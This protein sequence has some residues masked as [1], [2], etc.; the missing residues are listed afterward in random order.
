MVMGMADPWDF[1]RTPDLPRRVGVTLTALAV[2]RIGSWVPLPGVDISA[3]LT[4]ET[5]HSTAIPRL[6]IMALGVAP[7]LSALILV[8]VAMI[9]V[10]S[11]RAWSTA[12][13]ERKAQ[14]DG[15]AFVLALAIAA[16]QANGIAVALEQIHGL[17]SSPG[18]A[19]RAGVVTSLV[20]GS[21]FLLWIAALIT[22][23]G[24][25]SGFWILVAVP[26]VVSFSEALLVQA[27]LW[28]PAGVV[29]IALTL[30]L[31]ALSTA[32]LAALL[33]AAPPL[34]RIDELPWAPILGFAAANWLLVVPVLALWLLGADI[35]ALDVSGL[36]QS[37]AAI[38]LPVVTV[39]LIVVLRRRSVGMP[40][41]LAAAMP[42]AVA[43]AVL[44]GAATALAV[45]PAQPLFPGAAVLVTLAALGLVI[46]DAERAAQPGA[47]T[48]SVSS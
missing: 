7:F 34:A 33:K 6:S 21:A 2:Y 24:I 29:T 36:L 26:Y 30:G 31:L 25:G 42:L 11:L 35:G 41:S 18:L 47:A 48:Q 22:R 45:L 40:F 17:V 1:L 16:S 14:I 20:A 39:P 32:V 23:A 13:P 27:S 43:F 3:L 46:V 19:F 28:G 15:W 10:P 8:E 37:Q 12:R 5:V 4:P 44:A 38:L 9:V